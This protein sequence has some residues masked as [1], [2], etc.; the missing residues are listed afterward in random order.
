MQHDTDG[1]HTSF[2]LMFRVQGFG[3]RLEVERIDRRRKSLLS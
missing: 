2:L 3:L 1:A